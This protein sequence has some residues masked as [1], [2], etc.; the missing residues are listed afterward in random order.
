MSRA[1]SLRPWVRA[2]H[3]DA[4]YFVVGLTVIYAVSGLAVNHIA[5]FDPSFSQLERTHQLPLPLPVDDDAVAALAQ[6]HAGIEGAPEEVHRA[7]D[8]QL[9]VVFAERTLH[10]DTRTG[11]VLEQGQSPRFFLRVANWLHLNRGKR[12]WTF[13]AD[14]YAILLLGLA[15]SGLFMLPGRKGLGGRG[16]VIAGLG[17]LVPVVY[18]LWSGGP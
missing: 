2:L 7:D 1:R 13:I 14:G 10:V 11:A 15:L 17:V 3:R 12:A 4:G 16:A 5:D 6:R 9:D 18:V 8:S